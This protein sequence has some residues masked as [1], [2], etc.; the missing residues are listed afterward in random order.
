MIDFRKAVVLLISTGG[1]FL[2]N[3]ARAERPPVNDKDVPDSRADLEAIQ[4]N[5]TETLPAARKATVCLEFG[6][7]SGSGVI[8]SADGIILTAAHVTGGVGHEF[9]VV[10]E[11]GRKVKGESLGLVANTDCAMARII[12]KGPWPHVD[13]DRDDSTRLGDWV[14]LLG[15]SGG[16]DKDRG[17]PVRVGR[18]VRTASHTIQSDC[19]MIGGDSGGPVFDLSGRVVAINSRV[20]MRTTESLHVPMR[21]FVKN[22]DGMAK[23]EFIGEG[24]F[25]KKPEKGKG[26]LGISTE[27]RSDGPGLAIVKVGR[28]SPAEKGGMRAGDVL[29]KIDGVE[30]KSKEQLQDF[31][32]EKAPDDR[33]AFELLRAGKPENLTLRLGER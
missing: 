33:L 8:V 7:A 22:W 6:D 19:S 2:T 9:T 28:E 23:G 14:Y 25:A 18:V 26:F 16:Y 11:D 32:K 12:D 3:E 5:V 31:L 21:E 4:K 29:V 27:P 30:M 1:L 13:I 17:L 20:Q 10:F 24:E 15:Y